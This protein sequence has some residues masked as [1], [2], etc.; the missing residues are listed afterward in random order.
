MRPTPPL[1]TQFPFL[2][3]LS[4][5]L[6]H[7]AV[8]WVA[9]YSVA[10]SII[11]LEQQ[12]SAAAAGAD[13]PV[14]SSS[15]GF[16]SPLECDNPRIAALVSCRPVW[17][18]CLVA[19]FLVAFPAAFATASQRWLWGRFRKAP[20]GQQLR[21]QE[22]QLLGAQQQ[23][24]EQHTGHAPEP[25]AA[26]VCWQPLGPIGAA[27]WQAGAV[28]APPAPLGDPM[29]Q[30]RVRSRTVSIKVRMLGSEV[31]NSQCSSWRREVTCGTLRYWLASI[32]QTDRYTVYSLPAYL[33][34]R[35]P[36]ASLA[37]RVCCIEQG[38]AR[39]GSESWP[40]GRE[41]KRPSGSYHYGP[42][43]SVRR[44]HCSCSHLL[45]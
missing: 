24:K 20:A 44:H 33:T 31:Q 10:P 32:S 5:I 28:D 11:H 21:Q 16:D 37:E 18:Q 27:G 6:L 41:L 8:V 23:S 9:A 7:P 15:F 1:P 35:A 39:P 40:C 17:Q 36:L 45:H 14:I 2:L 29:Y 3:A 34:P 25:H 26:Q 43:L 30:S 19:A 22:Q 38:M 13:D 12:R 42:V 4:G